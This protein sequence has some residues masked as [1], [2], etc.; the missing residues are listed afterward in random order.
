[1]RG[2]CGMKVVEA[3]SPPWYDAVGEPIEQLMSDS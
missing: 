2:G 3:W 1:M